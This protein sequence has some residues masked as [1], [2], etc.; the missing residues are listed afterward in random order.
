MAHELTDDASVRAYAGWGAADPTPALVASLITAATGMI[1]VECDRRL[2][3]RDIEEWRDGSGKRYLTLPDWPLNSV[4]RVTIGTL[5]ALSII[6]ND[7]TATEAYV[8]VN[9][10]G[11]QLTLTLLDGVN[12]GTFNISFIAFPTLTAVAGQ[13]TATA[14]SWVGS[15]LGPYGAYRSATLRPCGRRE[16]YASLA[17]IQIPDEAEADY[18]TD[19]DYG[20][21]ILAGARFPRGM[22]NIYVEYNAGYSAANQPNEWATLQMICNILVQRLHGLGT[23]DWWLG[24]EKLGDYAWTA[25]SGMRVKEAIFDDGLKALLAPFKDNVI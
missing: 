7:A 18:I 3:E 19:Y 25:A 15:A 10:A 4:S 5:D 9:R 1:E 13:I 14:G 24:G 23:R 11:T 8:E 22:R 6:C 20:Q 12:A 2:S 21:V 17:Y 16:C